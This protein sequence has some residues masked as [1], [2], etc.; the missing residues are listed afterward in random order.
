MKRSTIAL[1]STDQE[2]SRNEF[3]KRTMNSF[4]G[5]MMVDYVNR[6]FPTMTETDAKKHTE[7]LL[8][9]L[10]NRAYN[11]IVNQRD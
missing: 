5:K 7:L 2:K 3:I 9:I 6:K 8:T 4:S 10:F 1:L 11:V